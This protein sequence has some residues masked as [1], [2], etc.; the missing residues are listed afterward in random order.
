MKTEVLNLDRLV[1]KLDKL[2]RV[3]L[4][5]PMKDSAYL[6]ENN[7]KR[8]APVDTGRLKGSISNQVESKVGYIEAT[9]GTDVE[10]APH[11]EYGPRGSKKWRFRPFLR[12]GLAQS[13]PKIKDIFTRYIKMET[14][15]L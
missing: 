15:K 14:K 1:R 6:V 7:A 10:Y 11:Q 5:K 9:I 4:T 2:G 8:E 13:K 12:P 3:D